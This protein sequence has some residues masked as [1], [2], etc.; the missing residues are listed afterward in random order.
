MTTK[1]SRKKSPTQE[2]LSAQKQLLVQVQKVSSELMADAHARAADL[3]QLYHRHSSDSYERTIDTFATAAMVAL[4]GRT[5]ERDLKDIV[6]QRELVATAFHF[7]KFAL[8]EKGEMF[9]RE[10][11]D[12]EREA[13]ENS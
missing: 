5:P 3:I 1:K 8:S 6:S 7:A 9:R 11:E 2:Q 12:A 4:I 10:N 13:E